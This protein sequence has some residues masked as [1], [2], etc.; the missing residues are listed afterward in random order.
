[1]HLSHTLLAGEKEKVQNK[2]WLCGLLIEEKVLCSVHPA[3][4]NPS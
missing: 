3:R 1:M 4:Q 2:A